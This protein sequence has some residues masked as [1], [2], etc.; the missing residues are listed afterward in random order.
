MVGG[1]YSYYPENVHEK[2]SGK[3]RTCIIVDKSRYNLVCGSLRCHGDILY[4]L[5][6]LNLRPKGPFIAY[7]TMMI[8]S[9]ISYVRF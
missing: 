6:Y 3:N 2:Q 1:V 8:C 9:G 7:Q 4:Y 5:A